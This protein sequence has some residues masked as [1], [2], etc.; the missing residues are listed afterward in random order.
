MEA[1]NEIQRKLGNDFILEI[2]WSSNDGYF[3]YYVYPLDGDFGVD[4]SKPTC[5]HCFEDLKSY[6]ESLC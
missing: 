3:K 5:F 1:L 6:V 4:Y 2:E